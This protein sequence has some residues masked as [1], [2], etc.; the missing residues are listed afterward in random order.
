MPCSPEDVLC[1]KPLLKGPEEGEGGSTRPR[2]S[3]LNSWRYLLPGSPIR[4]Q[5]LGEDGAMATGWGRLKDLGMEVSPVLR[6]RRDKS[7]AGAG[8]GGGTSWKGTEAV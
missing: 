2:A 8:A 1:E 6:E 5:G 7:S 4:C 3:T